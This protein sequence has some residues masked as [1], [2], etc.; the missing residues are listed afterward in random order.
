MTVEMLGGDAF[1][2]NVL[3]ELIAHADLQKAH[4]VRKAL[5]ERDRR[6]ASVTH[7]QGY[8]ATSDWLLKQDVRTLPRNADELRRFLERQR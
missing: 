8:H 1:K 2:A 6:Y 7:T 3:R 4:E 5:D